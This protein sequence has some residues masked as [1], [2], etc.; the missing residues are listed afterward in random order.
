MRRHVVL[1]CVLLLCLPALAL[2]Q[3]TAAGFTVRLDTN[4]GG[5]GFNNVDSSAG[6]HVLTN[7]ADNGERIDI[8]ADGNY[9]FVVMAKNTTD[10]IFV[11]E[12]TADNTYA[13]RW[14]FDPN[15]G[16]GS[17]PVQAA[18]VADS[19][20]DGRLELIY[21]D[22]STLRVF[23]YSGAGQMTDGSNPSDTP[24]F[25]TALIGVMGLT[26]GDLD[27][28]GTREIL[29]CS[30]AEVD[31]LEIRENSGNNTYASAVTADVGNDD[32]LDN[33]TDGGCASMSGIADLD[34]DGTR[35]VVV[36][37]DEEARTLNAFFVYR[38]DGSG[39]ITEEARL[40]VAALVSGTPGINN[41]LVYDLD[42][43]G[44]PE[45]ILTE[46]ATLGVYV[47]ESTAA[48]TYAAD[49]GGAILN[50]VGNCFNPDVGD[51]DADGDLEIYLPVDPG[52]NESAIY[53]EHTGAAGAF[54]GSDFAA[55]V[56][57]V[58]DIGSDGAGGANDPRGLAYGQGSIDGAD[59][60]GDIVLITQSGDLIV[61]EADAS[62]SEVPVELFSFEVH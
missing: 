9:E 41:V 61:V 25:S 59:M 54:S 55:S 49:A 23:E 8:D 35:E 7:R 52:G 48:N 30:A 56:E 47:Y 4:L 31:A 60:M 24:V 29:V 19:D 33:D 16:T 38:W 45:I 20:H 6:V 51:F 14:G 21:S 53:V 13:F 40:P 50:T 44:N 5:S 57:F 43:A 28:D 62:G 36:A 32:G 1:A 17:V 58:T 3:T 18:A 27:S 12:S 42:A 37:P 26:V 15:A 10:N 11:Y 39:T 2:G 34:G 22:G 46:N